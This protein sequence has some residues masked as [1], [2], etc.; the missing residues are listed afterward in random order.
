MSK[1]GVGLTATDTTTAP[2]C[3]ASSVTR[4]VSVSANGRPRVFCADCDECKQRRDKCPLPSNYTDCVL[5]HYCDLTG[6]QVL[7]G[8][9]HDHDEATLNW[10]IA[11]TRSR[12]PPR[13]RPDS[14]DP[15][16][17]LCPRTLLT[18]GLITPLLWRQVGGVLVQLEE[19]NMLSRTLAYYQADERIA[20]LQVLDVERQELARDRVRPHAH[21]ALS[22]K[23]GRP[24]GARR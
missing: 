5:E 18:N 11:N 20:L 3:P 7:T 6:A 17:A 1:P 19:R 14:D 21:R 15:G 24:Q 10:A 4:G 9:A 22:I 13:S 23:G 12:K 8:D 2:E 16:T